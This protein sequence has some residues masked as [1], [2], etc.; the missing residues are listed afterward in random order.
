M[1][2][3][4]DDLPPVSPDAQAWR[5]FLALQAEVE[6][7]LAQALQRGHGLG[8]SEYRALE[9]LA[10]APDHERRMQEL[11]GRIGLNQSSVT[12]LVARLEALGYA[13]KDLC[14]DDK[15]GVYAVATDAGCTRYE[16]ARP[17]YEATLAE[18]LDTATDD[19]HLAPAV[20]ALRMSAVAG[21]GA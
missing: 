4:H 9:D 15:R 8:L 5:R 3:R 1:S 2:A 11:A 20:A 21:P 6:G 7:R 12:R 14:P 19:P 10:H 16:Q 13:F 17:T 18:T